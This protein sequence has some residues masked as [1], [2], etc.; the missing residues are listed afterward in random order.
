MSDMMD[1]RFA[2][3]FECEVLEELPGQ[4]T[5]LHYFPG[6]TA[7]QDGLVV[8]VVPETFG[9]WTGVFAFGRFGPGG[10]TRILSMP[11][12]ECL[13]VISRGAGYVVRV[14]DPSAWQKVNAIPIVDVRPIPEAGLVVF[15]NYTELLA[16]D[17]QGTRWRTKRLAWDGFRILIE[18]DRTLVGEYWDNREETTRRFEVDLGTGETRGGIES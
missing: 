3:K 14:C 11:D 17:D 10:L 9:A 5:G 1:L 7:G 18:S 4:P 12:P 16:Y 8:R 13:C 6:Q 15:A 2:H